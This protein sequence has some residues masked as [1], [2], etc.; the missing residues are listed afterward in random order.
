V[1]DGFLVES[2]LSW[3]A[4]RA[5]WDLSPGYDRPGHGGFE[6]PIGNQ[7]LFCHVGQFETE[8]QSFHRFRITEP[9]I[10]CERCHGPG[11]L[12][13]ARWVK[14][15]ADSDLHGEAD[16]TIVNPRRLSRDLAE[17]VCQ[18]CH[19]T[20]T[21]MV[22][23][24][25]R[26]LTDYRPGLPFQDVQLIYQQTGAGR[27][28]TVTGHVEQLHQSPCYQKSGSLTCTTCHDPHGFPRPKERVA[29][30]RA[31]CLGCHAKG[32]C[33]VDPARREKESPAN[34][35][36][37]CHMPAGRINIPHLAFSH[38]RIGIHRDEDGRGPTASADLPGGG[39][40]L[41]PFHDLS[42]LGPLDRKRGLGLA[43][44]K[45]ASHQPGPQAMQAFYE[46]ARQ[47]L[48]E[49]WEAGLRDGT[50]ART[51]SLVN[52][53]L[54]RADVRLYAE[55]ALDDPELEGQ[56]RCDALILLA[57][58]EAQHGNYARAVQSLRQLTR[59]R[60]DPVDWSYLARCER[61]CGHE[62]EALQ[63]LETAARIG[64][65]QARLHRE[66]AEIYDR[67]GDPERAAWHRQRIPAR[68][69]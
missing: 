1:A 13:V 49:V 51:L 2:P 63:A 45:S 26:K 42:R 4:A 25:G 15:D 17:S 21:L 65:G 19:L 62:A 5:Q 9:T 7:C 69:E 31:A 47:L 64:P 43:Y 58:D 61:A 24:R 3:Y 37:Q 29:Y 11:E 8:G 28:M 30:Y 41:E 66:L 35:C 46:R 10:G 54:G 38:H 27:N 33:K 12:H 32:S 56:D 60:R 59:L 16:D 53:R 23:A 52:H 14:D 18:Q 39:E 68:T 44:A 34:S 57:D 48:G 6:R 40:A 67:R 50:V 20:G 36:I 55:C 22:L